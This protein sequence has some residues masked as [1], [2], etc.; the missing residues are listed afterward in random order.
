M[1]RQILGKLPKKNPHDNPPQHL[2]TYALHADEDKHS[3]TNARIFATFS[4]ERSTRKSLRN[5]KH[6]LPHILREHITK[7]S[8]ISCAISN[9]PQR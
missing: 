5:I 3:E 1:N 9:H 4:Y 8:C 7:L 6:I 2:S